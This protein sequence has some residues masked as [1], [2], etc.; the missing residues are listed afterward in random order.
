MSTPL[1]TDPAP[2]VSRR[3]RLQWEDAQQAWVLL[4]PEGMVKLN[5]SAGEILRR[6]DGQ[7]T[8]DEMVADLARGYDAPQDEVAADVAAFLQEWSDKLLVR[9]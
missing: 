5:Q 9:L 7:T 8:V 3:F 4:Y 6:C 1:A 2:R